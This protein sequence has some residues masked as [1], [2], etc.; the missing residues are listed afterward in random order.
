VIGVIGVIAVIAVVA[1][2]V[3]WLVGVAEAAEPRSYDVVIAGRVSGE[4]TVARDGDEERVHYEYHDRGR[5][6]LVDFTLR[7]LPDTTLAALTARGHGDFGD[8]I[9]ER[10]SR[11]GARARWHSTLEHGEAAA[12][13]FYVP[14]YGIAETDALL[15][16][17]LLAAGRPL[18][19]LPGGQARITR[20]AA[21]D[22]LILYAIDGLD[23]GP[24]LVWLDGKGALFAEGDAL[25]MTIRH[26][27]AARV[28]A[29]EKAQEAYL[30]ERGREQF[31][32]LG[33]RPAAG[34]VYRDVRLFDARHA[35]VIAGQTV[36]IVGDK[37]AA[38]GPTATVQLPP[39]AEVIEGH[40]RT[41]LPGLWDM[42]VHLGQ[43]DGLLDIAAGVT[44]VRD[45]GN[46]PDRVDAQARA[47]DEGRGIGPHVIAAGIV[48]G[49][50]PFTSPTKVM[51]D[52]VDEAWQA[53]L[54][55]HRRGYPQLKIY[56]S[57]QPSL[58][59][60]LVAVAHQAGMRVSGHVPRG[61]SPHEAVLAGFDEIQHV[62]SLA[63]ELVPSARN[64]NGP[65]RAKA[66]VRGLAKVDIA[67][68]EAKA[69]V[70]LLG[71]HDV[72]IDPTLTIEECLLT[73]RAGQMMPAFA[74]VA[75]RFPI[76]ERRGLLGGGRPVTPETDPIH[77]AA[78][79]RML[80]LVRALHDNGIRIVAG[81]DNLPGFTLDR[82][83]ELYVQAGIPAPAV[84]RLATLGAAEVMG[85]DHD[86]GAIEP[87]LRADVV[88]V[89]GDPAARIS[90]V[91]RTV[92]V[93]R[94]G[95]RFLADGLR[96]AL[97]LRDVKTAARR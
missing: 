50:G 40:G 58:V 46:D 60:T 11:E 28:S 37:I 47:W 17:A 97:N 89:D 44:T 93:V 32:R 10:F 95:V 94:G 19:V 77:R 15:A 49:R 65:E 88:L 62:N 23:F 36:V 38:V 74:A 30:Q 84:L 41:L 72:V 66:V 64:L 29:L 52:T 67:G 56:S 9:D 7:L 20:A 55:Y 12:G 13:G 85:R 4:L 5:G 1:L 45:L 35:R 39:G 8:A 6:P 31:A 80:E 87:G 43:N 3:G 33:D 71:Q 96:A 81:T 78:F 68:P 16:A 61:M 48:D 59:P 34:L 69:L 26:G 90:D 22:D 24:R 75:D 51:A 91:R 14:G 18:P 21:L 63:P 27:Q 82:E 83:L 53:V 86:V 57:V 2:T 25:I 42:H 76:A 70:S 73:A 92:E 54:G 79:A